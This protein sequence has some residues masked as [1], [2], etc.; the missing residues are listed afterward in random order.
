MLNQPIKDLL[1]YVST[2]TQAIFQAIFDS[3]LNQ[4]AKISAPMFQREPKLYSRLYLIQLPIINFMHQQ[5]SKLFFK[6]YSI[7]C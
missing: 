6:L 1:L 3:M 5:E 4:L 2:R 7:Q